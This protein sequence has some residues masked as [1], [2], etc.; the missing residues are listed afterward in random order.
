MANELGYDFSGVDAPRNEDDHYG[1]RYAEFVVPLVKAVQ[2]QQEMIESQKQLFLDQQEMI[3]SQKQLFF[4]QQQIIDDQQ[5]LID[6]L[7][8]EVDNLKNS[9]ETISSVEHLDNLNIGLE[10]NIPNPF[11][12]QTRIGY[13]TPEDCQSS[14]I[15]VFNMNG[16]LIMTI[17]IFQQG[18][19]E[20]VINGNQL[21]AGMYLYSL[22]VEGQEVDT[23]RMILSE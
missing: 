10:Q 9:T 2:E 1:L 23:K 14:Q 16:I 20:I 7:R 8:D 22:I 3:D 19:G 21:E 5:Q 11:A 17:D 15:L 6:D 13:T 12:E 18:K 4:D